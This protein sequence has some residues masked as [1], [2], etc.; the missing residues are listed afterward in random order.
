VPEQAKK[1]VEFIFASTMD[2]V[3]NAALEKSP[4]TQ[5]AGPDGTGGAEPEKE[6]GK[7]K[8]PESAVRA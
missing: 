7:K 3:L 1:E 5:A 2:D 4:F 8:V 6:G